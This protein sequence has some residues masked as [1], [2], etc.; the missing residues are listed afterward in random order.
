MTKF[1]AFAVDAFGTPLARYD[2]ASKA[3]AAEHEARQYL[4]RHRIIEV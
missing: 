3:E 4:K 1:I 2:L